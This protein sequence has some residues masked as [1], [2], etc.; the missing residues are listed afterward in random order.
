MSLSPIGP[1]NTINTGCG[2]DN[3]HISKADGLAGLLGLYKVEINGNTQYMTKQQLENTNFNLGSGNDTLVVD[4]NVTADIHAN[5][6][7]GNDVMIG[8]AGDDDLHGGNGNDVIAGRGGNDHVDGGN[9]HDRLFGGTGHDHV[10]GGRGRDYADGGPGNDIVHGG[11]GND[12]VRGG[13]GFDWVSG[14]PGR[15]SVRP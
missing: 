2:N 5:G 7:N 4:S 14:G 8:G 12:I 10:D 3:V 1:A 6:G 13:P 9:G 15:D 11:P